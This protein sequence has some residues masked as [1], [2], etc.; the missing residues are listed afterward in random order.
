MPKV[1]RSVVRVAAYS[2]G[3]VGI[4]ERH[5][6]RKNEAYA[7]E[8][9]EIDRSYLNVHYKKCETTYEQALE[10]LLDNG[11]VSTRGLKPDAKLFDEFVFDINT[12]YFDANGGYEYAKKFYQD[13]YHFAEKEVGGSQYIISAVM[14]ADEKN[15]GLSL[16]T[17]K[18][19]Y[20]YHLHVVALPV[21]EKQVKY[22]TKCKNKALVGTV[23]EVINQISHS[24]KWKSMQAVDENGNLKYTKKGKPLLIPSYSPLQDRYFEHM[25][26]A[27]YPDFERGVKGSTA[28]HL[29]VLDYKIKQDKLMLEMLKDII[30][31]K[32]IQEDWLQQ[33]IDELSPVKADFDEIDAIGKKTVLGKVQ[34]L[35]EE[36]EKLKTLAKEAVK[37]RS[38][39]LEL[40]EK[41]G[42]ACDYV[43]QLK[44]KINELTDE[45]VPYREALRIGYDKVKD[46]FKELFQLDKVEKLKLQEEREYNI[47]I[48]PKKRKRED[49]E[50]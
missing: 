35:P 25:S 2:S 27:G 11:V 7:N 44:N 47:P 24:K 33:T 1:N 4:R 30:E 20:H 18:D 15:E 42:R 22:T 50:R 28:E 19:V 10:K 34:M 8:S 16:L 45:I 37:S 9:V 41:L 26:S 6:E 12:E 43:N 49:Y 46:F 13:A 31:E 39:I 32:R 36:C 23:K 21:V 48:T 17:G 3:S 5:N 14:H 40:K 38:V 29:S